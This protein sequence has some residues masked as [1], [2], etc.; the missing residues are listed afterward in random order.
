MVTLLQ[1][2]SAF[3]V[4]IDSNRNTPNRLQGVFGTSSFAIQVLFYKLPS[5]PY[6]RLKKYSYNFETIY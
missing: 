4:K 5:S 1:N 6:V 3:H 2:T